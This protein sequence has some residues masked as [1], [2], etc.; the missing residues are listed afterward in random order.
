M[1]SIV[2]AD[3]I[4]FDLIENP[5]LQLDSNSEIVRHVGGMIISNVK[6]QEQD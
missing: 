3:L 5:N 1:D 4:V 6:L 2:V